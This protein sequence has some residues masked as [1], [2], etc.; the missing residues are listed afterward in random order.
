M[1]SRRNG[2]RVQSPQVPIDIAHRQNVSHLLKQG[3]KDA[4]P[5][6]HKDDGLDTEEL[7]NGIKGPQ[8]FACGKVK[9]E[10]SVEGQSDGHVVD[11]GDV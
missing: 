2:T 10:Q 8:Q 6:G 4:L 5:K 7:Q 3:Q 1:V 11:Q 9:Q